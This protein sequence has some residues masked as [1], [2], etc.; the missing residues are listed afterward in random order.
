MPGNVRSAQTIA[1]I[2]RRFAGGTA[3][4]ALAR[5]F[6][7]DRSVIERLTRGA[8]K[9]RPQTEAAPKEGIERSGDGDTECIASASRTIRTVE[10]LVREADVDL[11]VWEIERQVVNKWDNVARIGDAMVATEL[12]QI[13]LWLK[14]RIAKPH[15]DAFGL[16]FDRLRRHAPKFPR[17]SHPKPSTESHLLEVDLFDAHLGKKAWGAANGGKDGNLAQTTGVYLGTLN[18]L[19]HKVAPYRVDR[20]LFPVGNDFFQF[21]NAYGTTM[22]GTRV[23]CDGVLGEV[24]DAGCWMVAQAAALC[25]NV[26]PVE[27]VFVPGNHDPNT[28]FFLIRW[29][30]AYFRNTKDV[31]VDRSPGDRK[32]RRYGEN[33]IMFLHGDKIAARDMPIT[34]ATEDRR[35]WAETTYN[36][37]HA[38][39]IHREKEVSFVKTDTHGGGVVVRYL[40]SLSVPDAYHYGHGWDKTVRAADAF[41]WS[42]K[43]GPPAYIPVV[44]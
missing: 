22:K 23:D 7:V 24:F 12:W 13:K 38:G 2:K 41:L 20:I 37:I 3:V 27:F 6:G 4:R 35:A 31:A 21:D 11:V 5:E 19:L 8:P 9:P 43:A 16:L 15:V 17:L 32:V 28:A 42:K 18:N 10:D 25:L 34:M 1:E 30:A 29:L 40:H 36:E 33:G 44:A 26:A 39:H 14:R